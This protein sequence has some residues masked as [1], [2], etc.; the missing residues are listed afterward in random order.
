MMKVFSLQTGI[1]NL[2]GAKQNT[3]GEYNMEQKHHGLLS[4]CPGKSTVN[5]AICCFIKKLPVSRSISFSIE[6]AALQGFAE[7]FPRPVV[8]N[9]CAWH[10][11]EIRHMKHFQ[12]MLSAL[13]DLNTEIQSALR[14]C[15]E[16]K[17]PDWQC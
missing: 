16:N 15:C 12:D 1:V 4:I 3:T 14:G 9:Q 8:Q 13:C 17:P 7:V 11:Q 6:A 10:S 5:C 2:F